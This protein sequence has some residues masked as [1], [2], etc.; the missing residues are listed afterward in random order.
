[1]KIKYYHT[2]I[3]SQY[4]ILT[5]HQNKKYVFVKLKIFGFH[6]LSFYWIFFYKHEIALNIL[7]F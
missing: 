2:S 1:M 7:L 6:P 3:I 5:T 4:L